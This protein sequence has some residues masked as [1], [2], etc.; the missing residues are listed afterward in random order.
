MLSIIE[1]AAAEHPECG[2]GSGGGKF[3]GW[4]CPVRGF[5]AGVWELAG[6]VPGDWKRGCTVDQGANCRTDAYGWIVSAPAGA[7][8]GGSRSSPTGGWDSGLTL[9]GDCHASVF[10]ASQ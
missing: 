1:K 5:F 4:F 8:T 6:A 3:C 2:A 10:T 9:G 7:F